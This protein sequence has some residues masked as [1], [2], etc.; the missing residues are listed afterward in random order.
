MNILKVLFL[1]ELNIIPKTLLRFSFVCLTCLLFTQCKTS[2]QRPF[3]PNSEKIYHTVVNEGEVWFRNALIQLR[4]DRELYCGV[5]LKS[6]RKIFSLS[7]N[8]PDPSL[9]KPSHY[10][11]V[12][13][14]EILDFFIDYQNIGLSEV[15]TNYGSGKRLQIIGYGKSPEGIL[16]KKTMFVELY[17]AYPDI[18]IIWATYQNKDPKQTLHIT[19]VVNNFFRMD[20][21]LINPNAPRHALYFDQNGQVFYGH[22]SAQILDLNFHRTINVDSQDF[23]H[24]A[25]WTP[26]MGMIMT[27]QPTNSTIMIPVQVARDQRVEV[28]FEYKIDKVL[29]PNETLSSSKGFIMVHS[30]SYYSAFKRKLTMLNLG[31]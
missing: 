4:F 28:A 3:R 22:S 8:P 9:A 7:H 25:I 23:S 1:K 14:N 5:F 30:D 15:Q 20:A 2:H 17:H 12:Q 11:T 13:G 27:T 10:I 6:G 19:K 21:S 26:L 16:V 18:A 31:S 24:V 29:G